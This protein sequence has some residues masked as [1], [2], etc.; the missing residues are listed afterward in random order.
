MEGKYEERLDYTLFKRDPTHFE[1][2]EKVYRQREEKVCCQR[3]YSF[4]KIVGNPYYYRLTVYSYID[5]TMTTHRGSQPTVLCLANYLQ[6]KDSVAEVQMTLRK[7]RNM[8]GG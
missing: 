3:Y 1:I 5:A 4:Q 8:G 2:V 6:Q 7:I